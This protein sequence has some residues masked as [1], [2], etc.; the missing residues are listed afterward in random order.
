ME[1]PSHCSRCA[2]V[3]VSGSERG[4][5]SCAYWLSGTGRAPAW[6]KGHALCTGCSYTC[7]CFIP[8]LK[9]NTIASCMSVSSSSLVL[10]CLFGFL[11]F[12]RQYIGSVVLCWENRSL[13]CAIAIPVR[14][15]Q[16]SSPQVSLRA[17]YNQVS[18]PAK[19]N[20]RCVQWLTFLQQERRIYSVIHLL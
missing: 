10:L 8:N 6:R 5:W 4:V 18:I 2:L 9:K 14:V 13:F 1:S 12:Q 19:D 15:K 7:L 20:S 3:A 16:G 11:A 17:K